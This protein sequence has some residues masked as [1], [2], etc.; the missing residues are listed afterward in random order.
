VSGNVQTNAVD[1]VSSND[2]ASLEDAITIISQLLYTDLLQGNTLN[3]GRY[4]SEKDTLIHL[5]VLPTMWP[6]VHDEAIRRLN[7]RFSRRDLSKPCQTAVSGAAPLPCFRRFLSSQRRPSPAA[8]YKY[9]VGDEVMYNTGISLPVGGGRSGLEH[10]C[11]PVW[12]PYRVKVKENDHYYKIAA[13]EDDTRPQKTSA[14][15]HQL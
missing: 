5:S 9:A 10:K 8:L 1:K 13:T 7:N 4:S 3:I 12:Y 6:T 14:S 15:P 11:G 2:C